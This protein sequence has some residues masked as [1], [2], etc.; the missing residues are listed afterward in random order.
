MIRAV[1]RTLLLLHPAP[2]RRQFGAEMLL[3]FDESPESHAAHCLDG[4]QSLLRQWLLRTGW[5]K[6]ALAV[7]LAAAQ[8]LFSGFGLWIFGRHHAGHVAAVPADPSPWTLSSSAGLAHQPITVPIMIYLT[9]FLV[10]GISLLILGLSYWLK[11][12][13]ARRPSV[14]LKVR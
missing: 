13:A 11:M 6:V 12:A 14:A 7:A 1:Y 2:F 5:W 8:V 9:L 3:I 10:V 4:L